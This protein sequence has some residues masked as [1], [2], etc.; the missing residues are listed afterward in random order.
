M[1]DATRCVGKDGYE[2]RAYEFPRQAPPNDPTRGLTEAPLPKW[3]V[4]L[5]AVGCLL[6]MRSSSAWD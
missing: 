5:A 6:F 3:A 1:Q 4:G 2:I